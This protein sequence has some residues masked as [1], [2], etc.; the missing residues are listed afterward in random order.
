[1]KH[2]EATKEMT[3][4]ALTNYIRDNLQVGDTVS[5]HSLDHVV[6]AKTVDGYF[7]LRNQTWITPITANASDLDILEGM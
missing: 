4:K 5:L 2:Y 3:G 6:I 7:W 1:M